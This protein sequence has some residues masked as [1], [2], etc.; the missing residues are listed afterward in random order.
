MNPRQ[1]S[2][3]AASHFMTQFYMYNIIIYIYMYMYNIM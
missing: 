2:P 1:F 3:G